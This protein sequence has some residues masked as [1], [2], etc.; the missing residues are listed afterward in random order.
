[1]APEIDQLKLREA[2]SP[3]GEISDVKIMKDPH[4]MAHKGYGFVS[5]VNKNEAE[6]AINSMN[7]QWIGTRKI[8]TNWAT[9]KVQG[10][11]V[12]PY[13]HPSG[14]GGGMGGGGLGKH[15][16]G[17]GGGGNKLDYNEVW[18]R[19]S[20][21]NS[22]VYCGGINNFTEDLVRNIFGLYGHI[23]GVHAFPDRGYAFVR[24]ASK[25]AACTAICAIH[26]MEINGGT[27][28]CSWG[29]ENIDIGN[30]PSNAQSLLTSNLYG[31]NAGQAAGL[32]SQASLA[33]AQNLSNLQAASQL[34]ANSAWANQ[35]TSNSNWAATN[36]GQWAGYP[37]NAMNYWQNAYP[38]Y[39]A[40][41]QGGWGVLPNAAGNAATA[42]GV[43]AQ[44]QMG[45]QYGQPGTNGKS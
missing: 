32:N 44:Y 43:A 1:M 16:G 35:P 39:A 23:L 40:M 26:G 28:K 9:R 14:M 45:G 10:G 6:S 38:N 12:E 24:F 41:Q 13:P 18:S 21:T 8:R 20:D 5:F 15:M 37:Q 31:G 3:F 25:D 11:G 2:F 33:A 4:T 27:A 34:G 22:T 7:G 17:G 29:K 19:T 36:Y 30:G 42:T